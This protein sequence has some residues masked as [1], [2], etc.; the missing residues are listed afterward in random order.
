VDQGQQR[1]EQG[2]RLITPSDAEVR[3]LVW[4]LFLRPP[5]ADL[6]EGLWTEPVPRG[7]LIAEA[8]NALAEPG[9]DLLVFCEA[10]HDEARAA[11]LA[12]LSRERWPHRTE[13]LRTGAIFN[14][15]VL[16]ASRRPF[17]AAPYGERYAR[18]R[19]PDSG[20]GKGFVHVQLAAGRGR[21]H[22]IATHVQAGRE[23]EVRA[24]QFDQIRACVQ[25]AVPRDG[26]NAVLI[27]GDLNVDLYDAAEHAGML[28]R[29]QA[30]HPA[31]AGHPYS[32]D[33]EENDLARRGRETGLQRT[34]VDYVLCSTS[35]GHVQPAPDARVE[36]VV[37][38]RETP[39]GALRRRGL[40]RSRTIPLRDLSDHYAMCGRYRFP[41]L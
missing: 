2:P 5:V 35:E 16:V 29:L 36:T 10:F 9:P 34:L 30:A 41:E 15:G 14:A 20:V 8:L 38:R 6:F 40:L 18:Q 39:W 27:A 22:L 12:G 17:L 3:I 13:V 24:T 4:N 11:L 23:P 19:L 32:Y 21:L 28:S 25:R 37:L 7:R 1:S 31:P 33:A 26:R